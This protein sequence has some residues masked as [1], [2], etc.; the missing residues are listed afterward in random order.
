M[1]QLLFLNHFIRKS[2]RYGSKNTTDLSVPGKIMSEYYKRIVKHCF[3]TY[4]YYVH[5][6]PNCFSGFFFQSE[7]GMS[8]VVVQGPGPSMA[9]VGGVAVALTEKSKSKIKNNSSKKISS[10]GKICK[11]L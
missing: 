11:D 6:G 4:R 7:T 1:T 2:I 10:K 5:G 9:F 3:S 8:G